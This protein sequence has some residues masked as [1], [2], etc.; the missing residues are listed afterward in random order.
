MKRECFS[1][2]GISAR[3]SWLIA[4]IRRNP[5]DGEFARQADLGA[6][7]AKISHDL[8]NCLSSAMLTAERLQRHDDP[9][10]QNAANTL[11]AAMERAVELVSRATAFAQEGP[12]APSRAPMALHGKVDELP[13]EIAGAPAPPEAGHHPSQ[14][15]LTNNL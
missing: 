1:P 11:I 4:G 6:E 13:T 7:M 3:L 9:L 5:G 10:V 8:R 15:S 14:S 12:P 2:P